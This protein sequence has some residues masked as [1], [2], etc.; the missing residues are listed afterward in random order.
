MQTQIKIKD[1]P[2]LAAIAGDEKIPTGGKGNFAV[3][4]FQLLEYVRASITNVAA[5]VVKV[6]QPGS[7]IQTTQDNVN[8]KIISPAE[9]STKDLATRKAFEGNRVL[10]QNTPCKLICNPSAGDNINA[11]IN[12]V[13]SNNLRAS[14]GSL[15]LEIADGLHNIN[16][17]VDVTNGKFLTMSA[18]AAPDL[19][20]INS[21]SYT[22]LEG[23]TYTATVGL[24]SALPSHVVVGYAVGCQNIKSSNNQDGAQALN[25]A[26][27]IKSISNDRLSFT[28]DLRVF[29][30]APLPVISST[31]LPAASQ[32]LS[33]C[34]LVVPKCCLK[35]NPAGWNGSV[36]EGWLNAHDGAHINL[37]WIGMSF[38]GP[39]GEHDILFARGHNSAITLTDRCVIAG[40]GD[41][42]IRASGAGHFYVNRS[43]LGGGTTGQ[44]IY[45][46][47]GGAT[48]HFIRCTMGGASASGLTIS[49]NCSAFGTQ[50]IIANTGG[51]AIRATYID[52]T[53]TYVTGRI[54]HCDFAAQP[55]EGKI[56][57]G[58]DVTI[59]NCTDAFT[60]GQ[61][62][63]SGN[64]TITNTTNTTLGNVIGTKGG[65][66]IQNA[67]KLLD[68]Q[69]MR[70]G[71][72]IG[73]ITFNDTPIP[74]NSFVDKS[75]SAIG[76][77]FNDHAQYV[78]NASSEPT[79]QNLQYMA[80]V[81]APDVLTLRIFN[82]TP[83]DITKTDFTAR[84]GVLRLA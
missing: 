84:V 32:G 48:A 2:V 70:I 1:L 11:M 12:W 33:G 51:A 34:T 27:I 57:L 74:A 26:H 60:L 22:L 41:K 64:P 44:E 58:D 9:Y 67:E 53:A 31:L 29:G 7:D 49:A 28:C 24:V 68:P 8:A 63:V 73:I 37:T 5:S 20:V 61:G 36:Q 43:C 83:T 14:G 80:F 72:F 65:A 81:S 78:R 76:V 40:T 45:Q 16:T 54:V 66:W 71:S 15:T 21:L 25:G 52:S 62:I 10:F 55:T 3:T 23:N 46:G 38:E 42:I 18:T 4:I 35:L 69:F 59:L 77:Q 30:K 13:A 39:T 79:T 75:F 6:I 56:G 17:F 19:I 47:I 82:N 50:N